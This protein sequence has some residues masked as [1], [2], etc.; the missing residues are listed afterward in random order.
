MDFHEPGDFMAFLIFG[1]IVLPYITISDFKDSSLNLNDI[2]IIPFVVWTPTIGYFTSIFL[3]NFVTWLETGLFWIII[4]LLFSVLTYI[5]S[6]K[7]E[8]SRNPLRGILDI[9]ML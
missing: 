1:V 4:I 6:M 2:A 8:K 3:L 5:G 7:E 9:E